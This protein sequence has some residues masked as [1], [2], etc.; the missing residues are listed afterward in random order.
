MNRLLVLL[1]CGT[2][3]FGTI[4]CSQS[5]VEDTSPAKLVTYSDTV[6]YLIGNDIAR[7]LKSVKDDIVLEIVY[8]G[9]SEALDGK[10]PRIPAD[11]ERTIM[12][13]F[14]MKM[15]DK[16]MAQKNAEADKNLKE[17]KAFLEENGKKEGIVTTETGLQYAVLKDGDGPVPTDSSRVK[18]HYEGRLLDGTV[19]DSSIKRG[20]PAVFG[21]KQVIKGWTEVLKL[22]K[23]G[24]KY[25]VFIP[26]DLAYGQRG[27]AHDIGPNMC[28]IF[29]IELIGI[30]K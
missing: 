3:L 24:S 2:A 13:A 8:K 12:Q 19:F 20:E 16:Q 10:E 26:P 25:K 7:S 17:A 18:V 27:M 15:R 30:E 23:V 28:L 6:S 22:M 11:Q 1:V 5:A 4:G 9:I 29:D 21:I 14:S